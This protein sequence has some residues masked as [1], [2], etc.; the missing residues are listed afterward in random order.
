MAYG[1]KFIEKR[2]KSVQTVA[3]CLVAP[4]LDFTTELAVAAHPVNQ[5]RLS[6][7]QEGAIVIGSD[8][9]GKLHIC[10]AIGS[11]PTSEW[12]YASLD[13]VVQPA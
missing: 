8:T 11:E 6:G 5:H 2:P 7:K 9:S 4:V 12:D 13:A 3:T 10:I 1:D